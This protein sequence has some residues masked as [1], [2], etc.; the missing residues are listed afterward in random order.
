MKTIL[1]APITFNSQMGKHCPIKCK[2]YQ[3]KGKTLTLRENTVPHRCRHGQLKQK[4]LWLLAAT[5]EFK[6]QMI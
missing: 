5:I 2:S 6:G 1:V 4:Q 3:T